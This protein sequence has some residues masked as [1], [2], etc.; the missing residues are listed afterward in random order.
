V[1]VLKFVTFSDAAVTPDATRLDVTSVDVTRLVVVIEEAVTKEAV[2]FTV[3][4][5]LV[6]V[7]ATAKKPVLIEFV[8]ICMAVMLHALKESVLKEFVAIV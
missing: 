6:N 4:R 3:R 2:V 7:L 1:P 8:L 5:E